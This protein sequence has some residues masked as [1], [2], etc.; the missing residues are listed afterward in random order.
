MVFPPIPYGPYTSIDPESLRDEEQV[1]LTLVPVPHIGSINVR[2]DWSISRATGSGFFF[3][4][5]DRNVHG[6]NLTNHWILTPAAKRAVR[7]RFANRAAPAVE[8]VITGTSPATVTAE[9]SM[10]GFSTRRRAPRTV[11][12]TFRETDSKIITRSRTY[13]FRR[14]LD[15]PIRHREQ[16]QALPPPVRSNLFHRVQQCFAS[17]VSDFSTAIRDQR[18]RVRILKN[19]IQWPHGPVPGH[20][21]GIDSAG[22]DVLVRILYGLRI[23]MSFGLLL[24]AV[25]MLLGIAIGAVQGYYGGLTDITTQRLIEIWSALPFLYVM[26]LMGSVYGRSFLL[27]LACYGI[28]NWIGISYYMRAEF[29]RLRKQPFVDAAHCMG[30]RNWKIMSCHILPNALT[31]IITFFPFQLVGAIGALAALDYLGFGLPPPTPS[32][33][34]LLHQA[35]Q[36]RWAWWLI[37]YPS[38]ALFFVMLAGVFVGE[39]IRDAYDPR[40]FSKLE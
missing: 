31:P 7:Q 18:Y 3:N 22:R 28:F 13:T 20:W 34:E 24:V 38:L 5:E 4:T 16:W 32:W 23:S 1:E 21:L 8:T 33:G 9:I 17:P 36:F 19:D 10:P 11:R 29:L 6:L 37:L 25:S 27:L 15:E 26:I 30:I 40:P 39:G 14:H 2:T 35:Q 12:M